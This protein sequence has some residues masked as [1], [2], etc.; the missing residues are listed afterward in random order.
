MELQLGLGDECTVRAPV[1]ARGA[2]PGRWIDITI[3][4]VALPLILPLAAAIAVAIYLDSPGPVLFRTIR[5][6]RHGQAFEMFK[7]R[8]M[9]LDSEGHPVTLADDERF[10]PIGR[11]LTATR[12]DELPN[13]IN[14]LRGEMKLVGP[15]PEIARF[16]AQFP[17]PYAEI[18]RVTPGITGP[19]QLQ[20]L[21]E[22]NLLHGADPV[23]AYEEHILPAKI[24]IDLQYARNHSLIGDLIV[25][26]QTI[27]LPLARLGRRTR[28]AMVRS[29]IPTAVSALL[30]TLAFLLVATRLQ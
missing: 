17:E 25:L 30:L 27:A 12:L 1:E 14:V 7:F 10:T 15:R 13:V 4:L 21:D 19:A 16:V 18:V 5:I 23:I 26:A 20:F 22:R 9:R 29:W 28:W 24:L 11:F 6:G 2:Y 8:K 3:L